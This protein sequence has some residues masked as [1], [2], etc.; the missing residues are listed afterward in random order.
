MKKVIL[1]LICFLSLNV[2]A[3]NGIDLSHHNKLNDRDWSEIINY[4]VKFV[5]LKASEGRSFKDPAFKKYYSQAKKYKLLVGAYHFY[6]DEVSPREQFNNFVNATKGF[7]LDLVP[8]ID[9]ERKGFRSSYD[10]YDKLENLRQLVL[11]FY[12]YYNVYP[13]IYSDY[14][15]YNFTYSEI[16]MLVHYFW[17]NCGYKFLCPFVN[18]EIK[19]YRIN[20]NKKEIDFNIVKNINNIKLNN[21]SIKKFK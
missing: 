7:K 8:V 1:L 10:K 17:I 15:L 4:N 13:I 2:N 3:Q 19:Q 11:L 20:V 9:F 6:N 18:S 5:Y 14:I 21:N 16:K 12:D